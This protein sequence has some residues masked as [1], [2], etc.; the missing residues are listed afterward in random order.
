MPQ[1]A[2]FCCCCPR[3]CY[4]RIE[5]MNLICAISR[6]LSNIGAPCFVEMST[7]HPLPLGGSGPSRRGTYL[8]PLREL[9]RRQQIMRAVRYTCTVD[10]CDLKQQHQV[11]TVRHYT[12][13]SLSRVFSSDSLVFELARGYDSQGCD[14]NSL[15][16]Y[17]YQEPGSCLY[18]E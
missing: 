5:Q 17:L 2:V 14:C 13:Y 8:E 12:K 9:K 7:Q 4:E 10:T 16:L 3:P 18:L 15:S 11:V 6:G 1:H